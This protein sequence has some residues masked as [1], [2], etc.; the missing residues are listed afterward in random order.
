MQV[1]R[2]LNTHFETNGW[3]NSLPVF[4]GGRFYPITEASQRQVDIGNGEIVDAPEDADKA[5]AAA[6]SAEAKAEK[7]AAVA[8][9]ARAAANAAAA[10]DAMTSPQETPA[11]G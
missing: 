6:E 4:E 11:A 10:A 7:A 3:G 5:E 8:E 2:I 9:T 1:V